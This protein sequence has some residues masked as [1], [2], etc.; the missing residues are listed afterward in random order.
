MKKFQ[1]L[2]LGLLLFSSVSAQL[3]IYTTSEYSFM[4]QGA[5]VTNAQNQKVHNI[6]RFSGFFNAAEYVHIDFGKFFGIGIGGG[7]HNIG[8]I[9]SSDSVKL[10]RRTYST[11]VPVFF[12]FGNMKKRIYMYAGAQYDILFNFKQKTFINDEKTEKFNEW[13]SRRTPRFIPSVFVGIQLPLGINI[14]ATYMLHNFFNPGYTTASGS[15][16][17]EAYNARVFYLTLALN[18]RNHKES[19]ARNRKADRRSTAF[20]R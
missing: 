5:D 15:R 11:F 20:T 16:P 3:R 13:F 14:R 2:L 4:L 8:F 9:S 12:K 17:Y 19:F 10:K 18:F 7:I 1:L 6:I